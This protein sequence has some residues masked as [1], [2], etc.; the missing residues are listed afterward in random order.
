MIS[1]FETNRHYIIRMVT[2][3]TG[4]LNTTVG[5]FCV[6]D[7]YLLFFRKQCEISPQFLL[8]TNKKS[9]VRIPTWSNRGSLDNIEW[10]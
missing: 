5:K 8:I 6:F 2:L 4:A 10:R 7:Q 9:L 1:F 3:S